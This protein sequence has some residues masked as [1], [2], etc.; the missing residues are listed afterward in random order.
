MESFKGRF[1]KIRNV[2]I[3]ECGGGGA[4]LGGRVVVYTSKFGNSI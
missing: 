1:K 3:E 2:A 4:D